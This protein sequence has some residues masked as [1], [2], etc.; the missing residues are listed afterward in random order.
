HYQGIVVPASRAAAAGKSAKEPFWARI[1]GG[2]L[3][4]SVFIHISL[5][6]I[7][8]LI[9][10]AAGSG[11]S[12]TNCDS[13]LPAP[14]GS[15][16]RKSAEDRKVSQRKPVLIVQTAAEHAVVLPD[17]KGSV[18]ATRTS[19]HPVK[20]SAGV[21]FGLLSGTG[22]GGLGFISGNGNGL[23]SGSGG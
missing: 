19:L 21:S 6:C 10:F 23:G 11:R 12:M 18:E 2:S 8:L 7:A 20:P 14:G 5:I 13:V 4:W 16:L 15:P 9:V 1:G 17:V 22:S 3:S